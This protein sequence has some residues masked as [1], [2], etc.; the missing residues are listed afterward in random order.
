MQVAFCDISRLVEI[1]FALISK[2]NLSI[3]KFVVK[4]NSSMRL[5]QMHVL[6]AVMAVHLKVERAD[7][8]GY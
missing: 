4:E 7:L 1:R 5:K 2:F 3:S 6:A 8:S